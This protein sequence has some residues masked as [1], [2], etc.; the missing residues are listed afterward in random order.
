MFLRDSLFNGR[1]GDGRRDG[2]EECD[3]GIGC[4]E[5]CKC[6]TGYTSQ[7]NAAVDCSFIVIPG[8]FA[9]DVVFRCSF[10]NLI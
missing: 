5:Q 10:A 6:D 9:F 2:V 1:C 4:I 7:S 3:S 8:N